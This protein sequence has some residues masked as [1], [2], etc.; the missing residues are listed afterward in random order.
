[1]RS[2]A[3]IAGHPIHP[4]LVPLPIGAFFLALVGDL[5]HLSGRDAFWYHLSFVAIGIGVVTALLAAVFGLIDL[6]GVPMD[7]ITRRIGITH[8]VLNVTVVVLYTVS[9]WIRR[10]DRA[11][12]TPSFTPAFGIAVLAFL[13]LGVSGW[14]GGE[15]SFRH[16]VGVPADEAAPEPVPGSASR[17]AS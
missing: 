13:L 17:A 11:L 16:R 4:M 12:G 10:D 15:L 14:L 3:A 8:A 2:K 9:W 1:M 5:V 6:V 7:R